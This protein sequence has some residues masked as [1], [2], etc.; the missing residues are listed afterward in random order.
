MMWIVA[1]L[2]GLAMLFWYFG[3]RWESTLRRPGLGLNQLPLVSILIPAYKAEATIGDTLESAKALDYPNKEIIVVNDY[4]DRTADICRAHGVKVINNKDRRGKCHALNDAVKHTK[5]DI[6][7]FLDS[8][9]TVRAD[10]LKRMVPWFTKKNVAAVSPKFTVKNRDTNLLTR[11]ASLEHHFLNSFFKIHMY[12]GSLVSFWGFGIAIKRDVFQELG[13][14]STTLL[15]DADFAA[16]ILDSG[17]KIQ[18]EPSAMVSTHQPES[19]SGLKKQRF[20]W[21]KGSMFTFFNHRG[22]Y[23][24]NIQFS[25]YFFPY[26]LLAFAVISLLMFQTASIFI[27]F[28][29]LW[30]LYTFSMKEFIML[31]AFFILPIVSN[32][33]ASVAAASLA[34]VAIVSYPEGKD[35]IRARE[36]ILLIPYVFLYVPFIMGCYI[37]GT[38]SGIRDRRHRRAELCLKD[39]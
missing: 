13:G 12:F 1:A 34:H 16:K 28:V 38:I 29:S 18:Y 8:D 15:E 30:I 17:K 7:F 4:P 20:R 3:W 9:T 35:N 25:L 24:K 6:L 26:I 36:A 33:I 39:W 11:L 14:W 2:V 19:V 23:K 37:K 32:T 27:P 10:C 21:G 31:M 22:I 5:G